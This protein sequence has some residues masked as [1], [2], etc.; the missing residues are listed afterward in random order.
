MRLLDGWVWWLEGSMIMMETQNPPSLP[1]SST[2][3]DGSKNA[4]DAAAGWRGA[5]AVDASSPS[6][7]VGSLSG[8]NPH[9]PSATGP[10]HVNTSSGGATRRLA[11]ERVSF[12]E[13]GCRIVLESFPSRPTSRILQASALTQ[14]TAKSPN[15]PRQQENTS[16]YLFGPIAPPARSSIERQNSHGSSRSAWRGYRRPTCLRV[17]PSRTVS[18]TRRC[19]V[20]RCRLLGWKGC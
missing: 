13:F 8:R 10:K 2:R 5:T 14:I 4:W 6:G 15:G 12:C 7:L 9:A 19:A 11:L 3:L 17:W 16:I 1:F 20:Q 18:L